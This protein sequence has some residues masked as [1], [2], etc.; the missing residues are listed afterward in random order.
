MHGGRFNPKGMPALYLSLSIDGAVAEGSHGF[1]HRLQPL[2]IC[3]YEVDCSDIADLRENAG[4]A[5]AGVTS[6][7][8]STPWLIDAIAGR[9]PASWRVARKLIAAGFAGAIVS[10]FANMAKPDAANLV[11]WIWGN[12]PPHKVIVRDDE[13]RLPKNRRSWE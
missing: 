1:A 5:E 11:L 12:E 4:R 2:T 13:G 8:L 3:E 9:E 7:D 6:E 10:S